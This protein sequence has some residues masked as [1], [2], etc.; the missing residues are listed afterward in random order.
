MNK[1]KI[2]TNEE[3]Q[4]LLTNNLRD[5]NEN[6]IPLRKTNYLGAGRLISCIKLDMDAAKHL[7]KPYFKRTKI[8]L[9]DA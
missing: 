7:G 2:M 8:F 9:G 3:L 1:T 5:E 4:E 6:T